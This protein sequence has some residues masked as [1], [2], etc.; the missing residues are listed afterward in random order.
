M[1]RCAPAN[2]HLRLGPADP[3]PSLP[4]GPFFTA[5]PN[6][7]QS[8]RD[9]TP[10][11]TRARACTILPNF[12]GLKFM[13]HNGK[14]YLP[15][16]VAEEMVG[17][18]LGEFAVTRKRFSYRWVRLGKE[19][20]RGYAADALRRSSLGKPRTGRGGRRRK[21]ERGGAFFTTLRISRGQ[22]LA[23]VP[24]CPIGDSPSFIARA[25]RLAAGAFG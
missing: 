11:Y 2:S 21:A 18:K 12:V 19:Y 25:I 14:D 13:V 6:L 9:N 5:F 17:H 15:V 24:A 10:I 4:T 20:A 16:Q 1:E 3:S 23:V 7:A 22:E 8:L